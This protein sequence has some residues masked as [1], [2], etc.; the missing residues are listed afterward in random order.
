MCL[1]KKDISNL[2]ILL[3]K[4]LVFGLTILSH[5]RVR[6]SYKIPVT[7]GLCGTKKVDEGHT[8]NHANF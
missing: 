6:K 8:A 1:A 3:R 5:A 7:P 4:K 2:F